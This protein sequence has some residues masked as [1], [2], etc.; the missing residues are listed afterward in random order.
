MKLL[1]KLSMGIGF[2]EGTDLR[3]LDH[4]GPNRPSDIVLVHGSLIKETQRPNC[5]SQT[6]IL[7]KFQMKMFQMHRDTRIYLQT[8]IL[9]LK[10]ILHQTMLRIRMTQ[11]TI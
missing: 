6:N 5:G 3:T 8:S 7:K 2:I 4:L 9:H 10:I 1:L 11:K